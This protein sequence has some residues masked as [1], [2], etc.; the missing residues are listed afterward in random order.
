MVELARQLLRRVLL[1]TDAPPEV[2]EGA[3][4]EVFRASPRFLRLLLIERALMSAAMLMS[5]G[6]P[7]AVAAVSVCVRLLRSPTAPA[8]GW[9]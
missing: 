1:V 4:P 8:Q 9:S 7:A 3:H 2:P 6:L 5:V